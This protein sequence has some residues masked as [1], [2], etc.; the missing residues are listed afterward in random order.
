MWEDPIVNEIRK[1]RKGLESKFNFDAGLI[2]QDIRMRQASLGP[3]LIDRRKQN[4]A[5]QSLNPDREADNYIPAG[6]SFAE[7]I[8]I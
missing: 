6:G 1:M 3:R 7:S 2:F 5:E 4:I 8:E